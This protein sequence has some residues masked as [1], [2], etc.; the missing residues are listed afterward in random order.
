AGSLRRL[1]SVDC[2]RVVHPDDRDCTYYSRDNKQYSRLDYVFL[3]QE[4]LSLLIS[5]TIGIM[6][7]SD[8]APLTVDIQSPIFKPQEQLEAQLEPAK[9]YGRV[10]IILTHYFE[11]NKMPD[12]SALKVWEAHKCVIH[13][14]Y[15]STFTQRKKEQ[16]RQITDL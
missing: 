10:R 13:G 11:T 5:A 14:H 15:I 4:F 1:A 8:L 3:A 12:M 7:G 9:R 16:T 6:C 2:W